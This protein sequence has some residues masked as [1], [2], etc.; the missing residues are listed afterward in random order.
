MKLNCYQDVEQLTKELVRIPSV[1][2][3]PG[4]E[5]A[6]ARYIERWYRAL[7][8]FQQN[9]DRVICF[10]TKD[11]FVVRHSTLAYVKGTKNGGSAKTVILI[12]HIDT[13]GIDDYGAVKEYAC[14][15]DL[16]PEKLQQLELSQ[17]VLDDIA[18]GRYLF[19]RGAL[20]MKSGA[21]VHMTLIR[22]FSEHPE[23]ICGNLVAVAECDEE[24]N[25]KG[26]ITAL[27]ELVALRQKEGFTYIAGINSDYSTNYNPGDENRY[28]YFG[29]VGK[30]LPSCVVFGRETH[31]GQA[32]GGFDPNLLTAEITRE[33]SLNVD[34]CDDNL[35]EITVPPI[36]LKQMDTKPNYTVQ[37]ALDS[38]SYYNYFTH[39]SSPAQVLEN[40]RTVVERAM[41]QVIDR[42][43]TA[44][45]RYCE[46]SK[47][48]FTPL[49]WRRR[50]YL[51]KEFYDELY[52][53]HGEPFAEAIRRCQQKLNE[54]DIGMDLRLYSLRVIEEAWKWSAD[55]NPAVVIFLGSIYS[56]PIVV[57]GKTE[58]ERALLDSVEA[59]IQAVQPEAGVPLKTRM[60][61]PYISD[62]SFLEV[63]DDPESLQAL[64]DN[65][66][67]WKVKYFHDTEKIQ[68]INVP[69]VNIGTFGKDGHMFTERVEKKHTFENVPNLICLSVLQLL[70]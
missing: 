16:L 14:E 10:P 39:G 51:W 57:D 1:N 44:Y 42:L 45:R 63:C 61:Y 9:P 18:S 50:V 60:F 69:V 19:G 7:P 62:S 52:A 47:V 25:S 29:S 31:V 64:G 12:A 36:S 66:P 2:K 46:R 24:D 35:G 43:N 26:M 49:P 55:K 5:T 58:K 40:T 48:P 65:M 17:E 3:E 28:L 56:G 13:V 54:E 27:D 22:Y 33:M 59:A 11:D 70:A 15:P 34:L 20:D 67:T 37:T 23:E 8:Y 30:L 41:D 68:Q 6:V 4:G 32:F 38:L 53:R 21:A